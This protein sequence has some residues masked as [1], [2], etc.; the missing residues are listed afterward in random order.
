MQSLYFIAIEPNREISEEVTGFKEYIAEHFES[1]R[2][3]RSPPHIT[4]FPPFR[5]LNGRLRALKE[6]LMHF[7][8]REKQFLITLEDFDCFE[9]RV[10]F[11]DVFPSGE[12]MDIRHRLHQYLKQELNLKHPDKRP[13]HPH[14]TIANRDLSPAF[15]PEVWA[16]FSNQKYSRIF[17]STHLSLLRHEGQ[18]WETLQR[19]PLKD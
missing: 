8:E 7:A 9:S 4:L 5:Y 13:F 15:F 17:R 6:V 12:L 1:S 2:A 11:V 10:I 18:K 14:M 3:L 16:Y 19:F